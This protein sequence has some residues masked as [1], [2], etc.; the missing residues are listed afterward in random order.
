MPNA[1]T[2]GAEVEAFIL[3]HVA[4]HPTDIA[5]LT[6][7]RFGKLVDHFHFED[8]QQAALELS[9]GKLTTDPKNHS[10]QG[11]F[12]SSRAFDSFGLYSGG[13]TVSVEGGSTWLLDEKL[14]PIGAPEE[15]ARPCK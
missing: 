5:R 2:R 8:E 4:E 12:F 14:Y 6:A 13:L 11:I 7:E 3:A 9:K 10:G 15:P 1:P